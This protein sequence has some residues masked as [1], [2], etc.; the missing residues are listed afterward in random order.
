MAFMM[1][2]SARHVDMGNAE[3]RQRVDDD[4]RDG[5][6]CPDIAASPASSTPIGLV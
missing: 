4:V 1:P 2:A 5:D 3:R 6:G